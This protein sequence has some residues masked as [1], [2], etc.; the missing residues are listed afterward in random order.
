MILT[1]TVTPRRPGRSIS[2]LLTKLYSSRLQEFSSSLTSLAATTATTAR[3]TGEKP[4]PARQNS[5]RWAAA[6]VWDGDLSC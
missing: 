3:D 1:M 5:N 2:P 4:P 6:L